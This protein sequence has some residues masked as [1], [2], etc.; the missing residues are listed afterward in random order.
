MKLAEAL[1]PKKLEGNMIP[2]GLPPL[3]KIIKGWHL[4]D[5]IVLSSRWRRGGRSI[6]A[7]NIARN[8]TVDYRIPI[9]YFSLKISAI[10]FCSWL[11]AAEAGS[12]L[13]ELGNYGKGDKELDKR[14]DAA[15]GKLS[16]CPL[17]VDDTPDLSIFDFKSKLKRLVEEHGIKLAIIDHVRLMPD[18]RRYMDEEFMA[19]LKDT[20]SE[21]GVAIIALY[22]MSRSIFPEDDV[23]D[24]SEVKWAE[25]YADVMLVYQPD[26]SKRWE[27]IEWDA[28]I[29][30]MKNNKGKRLGDCDMKIK[31]GAV[32]GFN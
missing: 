32:Y 14:V 26:K 11:L 10:G 3:D 31:K 15:A 12:T 21:L 25:K 6:L 23:R 16:D 28:K 13:V 22:Q 19:D 27:D 30:L 24:S 4:S 17:Y 29:Y 9:A 8:L 2:T 5:L 20:A 7:M 1:M 18:E